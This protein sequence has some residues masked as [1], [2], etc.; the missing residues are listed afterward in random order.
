MKLRK[1][2]PFFK[3]RGGFTLIELLVVIA[4]IAILAGLLLPALSAAKAK[5]Q[6]IQCVSNLRQHAITFKI[7]VDDASGWLGP[8]SRSHSGIGYHNHYAT[9][10]WFYDAVGAAGSICPSAPEV[11]EHNYRRTIFQQNWHPG[12]VR[13]AWIYRHIQGFNFRAGSY[14]P[15]PWVTPGEG[16][17]LL[18]SSEGFWTRETLSWFFRS[19]EQ[20]RHPV[21]TPLIGDAVHPWMMPPPLATDLPPTNLVIGMSPRHSGIV[22]GG[23]GG[24][25][26]FMIPRH[27][28]R[29]RPVPTEHPPDAKLPGAINM[30]FFDGHVE[31]TPLERLWQLHWHK[32]YQPPSK[33]PGLR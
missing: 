5:A 12:T 32:N 22:G 2:T 11:A 17:I 16:G 18:F 9:H 1:T 10:R 6:R 25:G 20:V 28:S 19:E 33:R 8:G 7:A 29:P 21:S 24:M 26:V 30:A 14:A 4:I 27:G 23:E 13:S 3:P 31:L 15:N